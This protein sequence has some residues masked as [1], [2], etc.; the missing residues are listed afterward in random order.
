[1]KYTDYNYMVL[2][3]IVEKYR[4]NHGMTKNILTPVEMNESGM[5]ATLQEY[6]VTRR[7]ERSN[8]LIATPRLKMNWLYGCGEIHTTVEDMK[9]IR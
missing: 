7:I 6:F 1:M 3:Y 8:K 4:I 5:G 9:K 2:A